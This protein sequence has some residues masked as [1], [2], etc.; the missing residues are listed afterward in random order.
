MHYNVYPSSN[1]SNTYL[2]HLELVIHPVS[3]DSALQFKNSKNKLLRTYI[4]II[5]KHN[6]FSAAQKAS[7]TDSEQS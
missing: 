4:N 5:H 6:Q 7:E 1:C 3:V 2:F